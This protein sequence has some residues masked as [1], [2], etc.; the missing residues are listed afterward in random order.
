MAVAEE[1]THQVVSRF[2]LVM[3]QKL[4]VYIDL[5]AISQDRVALLLFLATCHISS[6]NRFINLNP[7]FF[8]MSA[9][10]L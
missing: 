7:S 5:R 9:Y 3:F 4:L 1:I 2:L 8:G 10:Q 6:I